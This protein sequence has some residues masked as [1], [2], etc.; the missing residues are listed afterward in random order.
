MEISRQ[1]MVLFQANGLMKKKKYYDGH[2]VCMSAKKQNTSPE[3]HWKNY[4]LIRVK[5]TSGTVRN[6]G[7][8][9]ILPY[10]IIHPYRYSFSC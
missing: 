7:M 10:M 8:V 2:Q 9:M 5:F 6:S 3:P 1:L 4:E